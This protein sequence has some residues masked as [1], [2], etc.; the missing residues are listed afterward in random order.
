MWILYTYYGVMGWLDSASL[1]RCR[2]R[3]VALFHAWLLPLTTFLLLLPSTNTYTDTVYIE[4]ELQWWP[5]LRAVNQ[6][7][8]QNR[9]NRSFI[10]KNTEQVYVSS[11]YVY[12]CI[13][14]SLSSD[15][16][17]NQ[18]FIITTKISRI[19]GCLWI[20]SVFSSRWTSSYSIG[21]KQ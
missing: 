1:R 3:P 15:S 16:D 9:H 5:P 8:Q 11:I 10:R 19:H 6:Q 21:Q 17:V 13:L 18:M 7:Q 14:S 20:Y 4:L 2:R 12:V